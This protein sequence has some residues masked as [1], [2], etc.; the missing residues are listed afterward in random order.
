M[1]LHS[2]DETVMASGPIA[3]ETIADAVVYRAGAET[4]SRVTTFDESPVVAAVRTRDAHA[5]PNSSV[6]AA[7][8]GGR[9]GA[10]PAGEDEHQRAGDFGVT[11]CAPT[12][13]APRIHRW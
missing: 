9:P 8:A 3:A 11:G 12:V 6:D 1:G 5:A 10:A 7:G 4:G 2:S 13:S